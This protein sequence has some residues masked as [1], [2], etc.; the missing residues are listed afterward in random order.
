[1]V[2]LE[3]TF[4]PLESHLGSTFNNTYRLNFKDMDKF[5]LPPL[6]MVSSYSIAR[7]K[8]VFGHNISHSY[9]F[10]DFV[11]GLSAIKGINYGQCPSCDAFSCDSVTGPVSTFFVIINHV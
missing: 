10:A 9:N 7:N 4:V 2:D 6:S 5:V 11:Y 8:P 3:L 1:M